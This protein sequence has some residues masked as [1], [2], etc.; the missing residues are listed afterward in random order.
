MQAATRPQEVIQT[1]I[2]FNI[3]WFAFMC[4]HR[5]LIQNALKLLKNTI[6]VTHWI[7]FSDAKTMS[8]D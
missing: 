2:R 5:N 3:Y 8:L 1:I 7:T 6:S 4:K